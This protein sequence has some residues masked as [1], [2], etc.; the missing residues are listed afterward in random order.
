MALDTV[1]REIRLTNGAVWVEDR[2]HMSG[3]L[4]IQN[5]LLTDL[6][7]AAKERKT[8]LLDHIQGL[9]AGEDLEIKEHTVKYRG[10]Y[11]DLRILSKV[12][13]SPAEKLA[14]LHLVS[15]FAG[16][17][18]GLK[19]ATGEVGDGI[20][21]LEREG[22]YVLLFPNFAP[23]DDNLESL[24][25]HG[26]SFDTMFAGDRQFECVAKLAG[27]TKQLLWWDQRKKKARAMLNS[28]TL[29]QISDVR[30][31]TAN[32]QLTMATSLKLAK[33]GYYYLGHAIK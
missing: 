31:M 6:F 18:A 10:E 21:I 32:D 13:T 17:N 4:A 23:I 5:P 33:G 12:R 16:S 8:N 19:A 22:N 15:T 24:E 30:K 27:E 7:V 1:K 2:L 29:K 20:L 14:R 9:V 3:D 26:L 25:K 11:L 28:A